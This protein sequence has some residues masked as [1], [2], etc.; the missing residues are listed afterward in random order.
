MCCMRG[1]VVDA[2]GLWMVFV[3]CAIGVSLDATA[4]A[5]P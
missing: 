4:R 2:H 5:I 3:R 1:R